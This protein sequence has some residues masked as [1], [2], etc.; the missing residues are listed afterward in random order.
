[1]NLSNSSSLTRRQLIRSGVATCGYLAAGGLALAR[2]QQT[3]APTGYTPPKGLTHLPGAPGLQTRLVSEHPNGEKTYAVIFAKGDEIMSGLTEFAVR[4]KLTAGHFS[5][6]G[7]LEHA[8]FGWFDSARKAFHNIPVDDQVE[9]ISL[10]GDLGLV[11]GSPAIHAHGA[12]ALPDGSVR[13]GHIL[14]AV[15]W[16]TLELFFTAYPAPLVKERDDET[17]LYLFNL[18]AK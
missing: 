18:H 9:M 7:A 17:N 13:G 4:E 15:A 1:M 2:A 8:L 3:P 10:I 14:E 12:V 6:I 11:N 16:P 5:A